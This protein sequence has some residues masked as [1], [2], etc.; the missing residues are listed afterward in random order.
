MDLRGYGG[1]DK[2]P[3]GYDPFT[4]AGDVSGVIKALGLSSAVVVGAGWGGYVGWA[5]AVLHSSEIR[6]LCTVSAP[7]PAYL[8]RSLRPGSGMK[9]VSHVLA[10]QV[11]W[12]PERRL[13]NPDSGY[14]AAHLREWSAAGSFPNDEELGRYQAALGLWPAP[15]C[16][17][18]YHRWLFRSRIRE[19]GRRFNRALRTP[20]TVPTYTILGGADPALPDPRRDRS[21]DHV[22]GDYRS[23]TLAGVGHFAAEE[24][25]AAFSNLLVDWLGT[26]AAGS[27][28]DPKNGHPSSDS[29]D[30]RLN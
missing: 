5:A 7:H 2:T 3:R 4:L 18:E 22:V 20:V 15:H 14:L 23:E 21:G 11:P 12:R 19:D 6:A 10:M 29:P 8:L 16:A 24:A 13:A 30:S 9:A 1:S 25:P 26:L 17:L 27:R 28:H